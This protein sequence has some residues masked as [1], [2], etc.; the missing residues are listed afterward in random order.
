MEIAAADGNVTISVELDLEQAA[1]ISDD[2][3]DARFIVADDWIV[4]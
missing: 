1:E 2:L 3:R 4:R